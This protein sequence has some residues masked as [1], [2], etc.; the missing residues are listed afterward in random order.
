MTKIKMELTSLD[1]PEADVR[2][3]ETEVQERQKA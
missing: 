3:I 2:I 1:D